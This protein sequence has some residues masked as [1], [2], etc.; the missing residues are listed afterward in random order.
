[1]AKYIPQIPRYLISNLTKK[2]DLIL[3]N[4]VGSGTTLV[5][6][7]V[8][9]RHAIGV[10]INPLACLVA[11][12]KTTN[13]QKPDLRKILST[14]MSIKDEILKLRASLEHTNNK[15][16]TFD[17][18]LGS[19]NKNEYLL[20]NI[21]NQN[22]LKWFNKNVI[23]ELLTIKL[24]IDSL[25]ENHI[26]DFLLVAFSSILRGSSNATSGF[27]NLMINKQPPKKSNIFE[28]FT[29]VVSVMVAKMEEF[30]Q[31]TK[32]NSNIKIF[33]HD[34]RNLRYI[35][36]DTI[37]FICTHPP[38][39][40]SVPFAEYQKLSLWWLGF[41]QKELEN[42]LIG[43]RR[44]RSDTAERFFQDIFT[45]LTEMKRVLQKKN[46]CCII[47]G[48]PI[49]NNREWQLNE[50][51]KKNASDVGFTLLKEITRMKYRLTMGR[52]KQEFIL[53]FRN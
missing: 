49:Y 26:R 10:D 2:N 28:K 20:A 51:I 34:T 52:M 22:I 1:S 9:G 38:Y 11:K 3:D 46:Y 21:P 29:R 37:S 36:D 8:L 6:S 23:Y 45:T 12:V 30:N 44:A 16:S 50:I 5:E 40:A 53:I 32:N 47:I 14:S 4:F 24:K 48:N 19:I 31:V 17:Q 7:K 27:G 15:T 13:I 43:G 35:A 42:K 25:E 18:D 33:N 41:S 39:M